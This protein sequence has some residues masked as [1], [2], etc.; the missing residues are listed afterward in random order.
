MLF[1]AAQAFGCQS[2]LNADFK[3]KVENVVKV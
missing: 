1:E 3:V 2:D